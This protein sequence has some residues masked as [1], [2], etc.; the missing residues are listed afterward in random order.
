MFG[1]RTRSG[2]ARGIFALLLAL[3]LAI[4]LLSPAGFMPAFDR[5]AVT[6]VI[7]PDAGEGLAP[8]ASHHH[9][10]PNKIHP[11]CPF[12]A[13]SSAALLT[14]EAPLLGALAI[15]GPALLPLRPLSFVEPRRAFERPPP[16]GPPLP[17]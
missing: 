9:H 1:S 10:G 2:S 8:K 11:P 4:R 12:A 13:G 14:P 3:G 7:C 6:I 16:R 17:V 15:F 5:G